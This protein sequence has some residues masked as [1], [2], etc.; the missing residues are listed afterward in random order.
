MTSEQDDS[1]TPRCPHC[2]RY[3]RP[4]AQVGYRCTWC[5]TYVSREEAVPR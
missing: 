1:G 4:H 3:L 2:M 5:E